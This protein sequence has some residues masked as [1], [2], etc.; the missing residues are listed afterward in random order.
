MD[1]GGV[2]Q[3]TGLLTAAQGG[4][5]AA[6]ARLVERFRP[7]LRLHCYRMLGS[8]TEADDAVQDALLQIWRSLDGFGGRSLVR[9]WMYR[10]A[11][12][13]CLA[14]RTRAR[15]RHKILAAGTT[16]DGVVVPVAATV[17]WLQVCPDDLLDQVAGVEPDADRLV[18]LETI[19]LHFIAALQ[20]LTSSQRAAVIMRDVL[21]WSA[22]ETATE[23]NVTVAAANGTL[24]RGRA[25]LRDLLGHDRDQWRNTANEPNNDELVRRY[26]DAIE[27]GDDAAVAALLVEDAVVSHQANAGQG[28][29]EVTWY[30]GR[31][32]IIDAWA[33]ALH[34]PIPLDLRLIDVKVNRHLAVASYA[35][36]PGDSEHRP[37]G[38]AVLRFEQGRVSE[39]IN[40]TPDQFALLDLPD[41]LP[42]DK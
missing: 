25:T 35:R 21:G 10:I 27:G 30:A 39:V 36:L 16:L 18:A 26:I 9:T 34:A 5:E 24:R 23:L 37:F 33:P 4:D 31:D 12:H 41:F 14:Y 42:H 7:E 15:R 1:D 38:L 29:A 2:D 8:M 3:Y 13:T 22:A 40:L 32:N 11:T 20:H 17:P 19:E 28:T 6:F